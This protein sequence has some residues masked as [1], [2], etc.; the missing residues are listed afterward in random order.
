MG[1]DRSR[2]NAVFNVRTRV[3]Q[4]WTL[5]DVWFRALAN[6]RIFPSSTSR[7]HGSAS[8]D[9]KLTLLETA[10]RCTELSQHR[11]HVLL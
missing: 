7:Q 10:G 5:A 9:T 6:R 2:Y 1:E 4:E 8:V 11:P 3:G